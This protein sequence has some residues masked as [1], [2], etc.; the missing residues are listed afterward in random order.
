MDPIKHFITN[1]K[2]DGWDV[3]DG[4]EKAAWMDGIDGNVYRW[5]G[6]ND[7]IHG[8]T[9]HARMHRLTDHGSMD[10]WIYGIDWICNDVWMHCRIFIEWIM[11]TS[12]GIRISPGIFHVSHNHNRLDLLLVPSGMRKRKLRTG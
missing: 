4:M 11:L 12:S 8:C 3:C 6:C 7:G 2:T 9:E 5:S 1:H 10:P